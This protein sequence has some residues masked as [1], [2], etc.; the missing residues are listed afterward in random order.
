MMEKLAI[1]HS[2]NKAAHTYD[3]HAFLQREVGARL[4]QRLQLLKHPPLRIL[5]IGSGTGY[6]TRKV[7]LLFPKSR[8]I[9][10]DLAE[11][12]THF[13]RAQQ[14]WR[15]FQGRPQYVCGD[16][17]NLPF[18]KETFDLVV[19]NL[20]LQWCNSLRSVFSECMRVLKPEG[21]F[22]FT[23]LGPYTLRELRNSWAHTGAS[24]HVNEFIDMHDIG[25]SLLQ[26]AFVSPVV[27]ME[28][29]TLTY[30][31]VQQLL[32]DL[33]F[34]GARHLAATRPM[35]LTTKTKFKLML[36]NY[37]SYKTAQGLYPASF[38]IIYGHALRPHNIVYGK[39]QD[40]LIRIADHIP[41]L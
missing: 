15:P 18:K 10:L 36:A 6:F 33:K 22:F 23:T 25:D 5:D 39:D 35:A 8:I 24:T 27:D 20:T 11:R 1:A 12:M 31:S 38:E 4:L 21:A 30:S 9:G 13:S 28:T 29:L 14:G 37:E 7:Q 26:S 3:A 41:T 17:G 16:A 40:G 32:Y 19:S 34:T 2:F